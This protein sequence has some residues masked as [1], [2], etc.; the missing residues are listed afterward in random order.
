M[1]SR[2]PALRRTTPHLPGPTSTT[3]CACPTTPACWSTPAARS[4]AGSTATAST[5]WPGAWSCSAANPSPRPAAAPAGR[6]VPD[7]HRARAGRRP[8]RSTTGWATT[9][10]GRTRPVPVTG[11]AGPCGASVPSPRAARAA[12]VRAE[13]MTCFER[14]A[15]QRSQWPRA[16]AF[17]ALGAAEILAG[18]PRSRE[19]AGAAEGHRD[20]GRAAGRA[21]RRGRGPSADSATPTPSWPRLLIV[22]GQSPARRHGWPPTGCGCWTG[23]Y[24]P[25]PATGTCRSVAGRRLAATASPGPGF[26]QQPIEAAALADACARACALTGDA[27]LGDRG[28]AARWPGSPAT[29]TWGYR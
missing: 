15:T 6:A 4:R 28:P 11:G 9:A 24:A 13:A 14:G 27:A 17:A 20:R 18:S 8:G 10:A 12:W 22:A 19:R 2:N 16:M 26:D 5:T 7:L 23:C 25:R 3:C 21:I 1:A 29:T